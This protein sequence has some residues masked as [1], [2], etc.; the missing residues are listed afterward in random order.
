MVLNFGFLRSSYL[1]PYFLLVDFYFIFGGFFHQLHPGATTP[2]LLRSGPSS[3]VSSPGHNSYLGHVRYFWIIL[4]FRCVLLVD[5]Y[6][7]L[8]D[9]PSLVDGVF[10]STWHTCPCFSGGW[11][12]SPH[13]THVHASQ[14]VGPYLHMAPMSICALRRLGEA[15]TINLPFLFFGHSRLSH[16]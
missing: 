5:F 10:T 15:R 12:L 6:F 8:A 7:I 11:A 13:G 1:I 3:V 16:K 14:V 2:M 4:L 9:F